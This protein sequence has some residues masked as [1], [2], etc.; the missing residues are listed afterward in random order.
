MSLTKSLLGLA[1]A[2]LA[3]AACGGEVANNTNARNANTPNVNS[4]PTANASPASPTDTG[5]ATSAREP[6][7]YRATYVFSGQTTG[8][9]AAA[10]QTSIE[11]ARDGANRRWTFDTRIPSVG[12]VTIL[13]RADKRYLIVDGQRRYV[14]LTPEMTGFNVPRTMT[15]GMMV[16]QVQRQPNVENLGE[17]QVGNRTAI[18]Y[19]AAAAAN[20]N[21]QAGQVRGETLFWIDKETGLPLKMQAAA[22]GSGQVQGT[23]GGTAG[24]E[25]RELSTTVDAALFE[26]PAGFTPMSEQ[27]IR[28]IQQGA[29]VILQGILSMMGG[30]VGAGGGA[31]P[32][33]AA[34]PAAAASPAG[35]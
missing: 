18:K 30:G 20:T 3:C 13:D 1:A 15:P 19:R 10:A 12:K 5:A 22:A 21:T 7:R 27:E 23:T 33:T 35:H 9:Q 34:S 4:S 31:A 16:E 25:L 32:A 29:G 28:Q 8:A 11:V 17:E 6:E 24:M 14:E 26:L 2:A